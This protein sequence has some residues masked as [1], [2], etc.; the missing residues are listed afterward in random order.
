[1]Y[2]RRFAVADLP[3]D[4]PKEFTAWV[5][6]RWE[7]KE[8]LLEQYFQTGLFPADEA[9]LPAMGKSKAGYVDTEVK[10]GKWYEIGQLLVVPATLAL[11]ANVVSKLM[12]MIVSPF[13][14]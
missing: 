12:T 9:S 1:M 14:R 3:L 4:D 11:L 13:L 6:A 10:L 5:T 7:E 2:W 8:K